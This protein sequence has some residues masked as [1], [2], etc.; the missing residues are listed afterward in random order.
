MK[1][2]CEPYISTVLSL[3]SM[4][5]SL[6]DFHHAR[7]KGTIPY[8]ANFEEVQVIDFANKADLPV[9]CFVNTGTCWRM[10]NRQPLRTFRK[11]FIGYS[12]IYRTLSEQCHKHQQQ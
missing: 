6:L 10:A 3:P 9:S 4:I 1:G 7:A 8:Q 12:I 11:H 5:F 2:F